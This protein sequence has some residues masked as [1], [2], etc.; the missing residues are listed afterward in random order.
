MK[1]LPYGLV[2]ALRV[3]LRL[4]D[5]SLQ[6]ICDCE[7]E[8]VDQARQLCDAQRADVSQFVAGLLH[9]PFQLVVAIAEVAA[10]V[11][12]EHAQQ[13]AAC[14]RI[15]PDPVGKLPCRAR[16]AGFDIEND[17]KQ[18][19]RSNARITEAVALPG[20]GDGD[21]ASAECAGFTVGRETG[22]AAEHIANFNA[23]VTV[24]GEAPTLRPDS[25]PIADGAEARKF[26]R[27][28]RYAR[29]QS[30]TAGDQFDFAALD[31]L[32]EGTTVVG[33]FVG[34]GHFL[35]V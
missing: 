9:E 19:T 10:L 27:F 20:A 32:G 17:P 21:V 5:T 12:T 33:L 29:I 11:F 31:R 1:E 16:G 26:A 2:E 15:R 13:F 8:C 25:V 34:V 7:Q 30:T 14:F 22:F 23:F 18:F 24:H 3:V 4:F 6:S 28:E 35:D